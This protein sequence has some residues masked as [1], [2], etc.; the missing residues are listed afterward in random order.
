MTNQNQEWDAYAD[1]LIT[2]AEAAQFL[3][4]SPRTLQNWRNR[5]GSLKYIRVSSR[6]VRYRRRD[7]IDWMQSRTHKNTWQEGTDAYGTA[8]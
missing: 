8:D 5:D 6:C 2:E 1:H 3:G 7:L 4:L